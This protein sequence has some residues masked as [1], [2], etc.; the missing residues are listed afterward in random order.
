MI[1]TGRAGKSCAMANPQVTD[2]AAA[3]LNLISL[4]IALTVCRNCG[5][6]ARSPVCTGFRQNLAQRGPGVKDAASIV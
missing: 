4:F 3:R 1:F 2:M 6:D 5:C